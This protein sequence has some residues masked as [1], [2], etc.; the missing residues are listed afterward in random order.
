VTYWLDL[1]TIETWKEFKEAGGAISGFRESRWSRVKRMKPGDRL[2]CY[3]VALKRWIAV[4]EVTSE[5]FFSGEPRIWESDD[6]PARVQV[7]VDLEL[8]L[9][10]GVPAHDLFPDMP[11][12]D[13][14]KEKDFEGWGAFFMGSPARWSDED[15]KVVEEAIRA[16]IV[17]PVERPI[18]KSALRRRPKTVETPDLGTVAVPSEE[19]NA[20]NEETEFAPSADSQASEHTEIQALLVRMGRALGHRIFIARNDRG[21]EWNG[22]TLGELPG[23]VDVLPTQFNEATNKVVELID[24]LWLDDNAIAAAFEVEKSTSIYSGLLRMSDLLVMQPNL[25]IPIFLVAPEDRRLKVLREVNR[26]TFKALKTKR[27]LYKACRYISF[28]NLRAAA[29]KYAEVMPH[30]QVSWLRNSLSEST[31][32]DDA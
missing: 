25:D 24:V 19:D 21:R 7:K 31:E 23:V 3:A 32:I 29:E 1:F 18:P 20:E 2:L 12:F 6:F 5:P 9:E 14:V 17:N 8:T 10:A 13:K 28:E 16:A 11:M 22:K 15:G 27:P 30:L 4:L 26:P